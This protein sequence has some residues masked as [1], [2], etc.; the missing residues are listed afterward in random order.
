[1]IHNYVYIYCDTVARTKDPPL[2]PVSKTVQKY[3]QFVIKI[4]NKSNKQHV[5][6]E[7]NTGLV[8]KRS[9]KK[10]NAVCFR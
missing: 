9:K 1:M 8:L 6:K 10:S 2:S 7:T 5:E 3:K 4:N